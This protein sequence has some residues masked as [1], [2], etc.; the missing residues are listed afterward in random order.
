MTFLVRK[1]NNVNVH[2]SDF[3]N[4]IGWRVRNFCS[5]SVIYFSQQRILFVFKD[6]SFYEAVYKLDYLDAVFNESLRLYPPAWQYDHFIVAE[7]VFMSPCDV[8]PVPYLHMH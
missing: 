6:E 4:S 7:F 3:V 2:L 1:W 5:S 8:C